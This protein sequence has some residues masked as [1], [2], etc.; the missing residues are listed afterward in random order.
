MKKF[1]SLENLKSLLPD[2]YKS[3]DNLSAALLEAAKPFGG[4]DSYFENVGGDHLQ[5]C[6]DVINPHGRVAVCGMIAQYN[7]DTPRPGPTNMT[8]IIGKKLTL[9]GFIVS[10][11]FDLLPEFIQD[12][13]GWMMAGK[14]KSKDTVYE[15]IENTPSAFMGLFSGAN[16]GK[17]LVKL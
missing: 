12:L 5:A 14:V 4:V 10:D 15:G 17:M 1:N 16:T 7:D 13:S 2:D 9:Q 11:Y 6:F 3:V 8:Q